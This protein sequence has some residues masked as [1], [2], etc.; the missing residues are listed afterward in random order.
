M[1]IRSLSL[2]VLSAIALYA[3]A[4]SAGEARGRVQQ[5]GQSAQRVYPPVNLEA[6]R[7]ENRTLP[8]APTLSDKTLFDRT[9]DTSEN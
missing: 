5:V 4:A 9:I 2:V 3:P 6:W 8:P 7:A 1:N